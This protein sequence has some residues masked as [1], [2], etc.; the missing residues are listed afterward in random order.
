MKLQTKLATDATKTT[1]QAGFSLIEILIALTLL[2]LAGTFVAGQ[3][4]QQLHEGRV[5]AAKIQMNNFSGL[6]KDYKRKCGIYPTS[7]QGLDALVSKPS[8]G[9]ECKN[10]PAAGFIED[11][12]LPQDPWDNDYQYV[13]D[14]RTYN[15]FSYGNDGLE[16]GEGEDADVYLKDNNAGSAAE[17]DE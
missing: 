11:G 3:I 14:G 6:L 16:G 17:S 2:G 9:R 5:Q 8:A 7:E 10:Y 12:Q 4:F 1:S 13:S 15:I